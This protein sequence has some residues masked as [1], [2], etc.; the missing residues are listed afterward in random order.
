MPAQLIHKFFKGTQ[1]YRWY[2]GDGNIYY[3]RNIVTGDLEAVS[4][5]DYMN[6]AN[7]W[8]TVTQ[9]VILPDDDPIIDTEL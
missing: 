1:E 8:R 2:Y 6:S 4:A 3:F 7:G 9:T 5:R